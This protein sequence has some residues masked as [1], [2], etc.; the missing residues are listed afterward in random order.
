MWKNCKKTWF[1]SPGLPLFCI[2]LYLTRIHKIMS[3]YPPG[4]AL[5][6]ASLR[7]QLVENSSELNSSARR[8]MRPC[9]RLWHRQSR[10][11]HQ[12][13]CQYFFDINIVDSIYF[14]TNI[15]V[16]IFCSFQYFFFLTP[17]FLLQLDVSLRPRA[18]DISGAEAA[19]E[20]GDVVSLLCT[21][22]A[23]RCVEVDRGCCHC[24]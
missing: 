6:E 22:T 16:S 20:S 14:D 1:S 18:V 7:S 17:F 13:S 4:L 9:L 23:A 5:V 19:V 10:F 3:I 24:H 15:V 2:W 21:S 11:W 8:T 12:Y